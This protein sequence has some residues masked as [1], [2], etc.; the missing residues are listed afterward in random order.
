MPNAFTASIQTS[1]QVKESYVPDYVF[2]AQLHDGRYVIGQANNP[3]KRIASIN[4]G[5]NPLIK[6]SLQINRIIGVKPQDEQR[7]FAGVVQ[8]FCDRYGSENVVAV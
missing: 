7:T 2:V 6:A 3:A 8:S 4:S 5:H 1:T